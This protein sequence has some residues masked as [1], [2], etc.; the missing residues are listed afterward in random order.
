M[1]KGILKFTKVESSEVNEADERSPFENNIHIYELTTRGS[2]KFSSEKEVP[3][4]KDTFSFENIFGTSPE[5]S[6]LRQTAQF[7]ANQ[8]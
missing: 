1:P 6:S 3:Q 4:L 8:D 7:G 2:S 5:S